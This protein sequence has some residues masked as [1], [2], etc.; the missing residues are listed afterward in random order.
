MSLS[1][2]Y[3]SNTEFQA[4]SVLNKSSDINDEPVWESIVKDEQIVPEDNVPD[5]ITESPETNPAPEMAEEPD[6]SPP[7]DAPSTPAQPEVTIDIETIEQNAFLSGVEAGRKQ[8][9]DDF[10]NNAQTFMCICRE[11]DSLR[12]T[13]LVNSTTEMKELV[14]AISEKIIRHSVTEQNETIVATINDAIRL[15]VKSDE[16]QIQ[17]NP[18]DLAAIETRKQEIIDNVS[19]LNN[20]VL[21]ADPNIERGGCKLESTCCTIDATMTGQIKVIHDSIMATDNLQET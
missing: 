1:R 11:L 16:F 3:K 17:I 21:L 9:E 5:T 14:L 13:I 18:E 2:F 20:I 12:E 8:A 15:A 10:E 19:G 4:Q 7:L 6:R